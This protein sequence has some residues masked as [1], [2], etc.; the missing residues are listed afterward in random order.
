MGLIMLTRGKLAVVDN[1]DVMYLQ[2]WKWHAI[3]GRVTDYAVR[4][5]R[6]GSTIYMHRQLAAA[7]G[8]QQVDHI[9]HD[10]LNNQRANLRVCSH[11]ENRWNHHGPNRKVG[12]S[13]KFQGV[14]WNSKHGRWYAFIKE[15]GRAKYLGHFGSELEAARAYDRAAKA[16]RG[17]FASLNFE[18]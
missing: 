18:E 7:A 3:R 17:E 5:E 8:G 15:G 11:T 2:Q 14:S 6:D 10:G 16:S 4:K 1:A 12:R 13:S 9:D